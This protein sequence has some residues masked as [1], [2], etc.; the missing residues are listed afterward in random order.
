MSKRKLNL[1]DVE[2]I[3]PEEL[4][5]RD[6]YEDSVRESFFVIALKKQIAL[7]RLILAKRLPL[8]SITG[9]A[10]NDAHRLAQ[11]TYD[12]AAVHV[13]VSNALHF[14]TNYI[15]KKSQLG[16]IYKLS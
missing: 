13:F 6:D 15:N 16:S 9:D 1:D 10:V 4:D 2:S 11:K 12:W 14:I 7:Q 8:T 3:V 5:S